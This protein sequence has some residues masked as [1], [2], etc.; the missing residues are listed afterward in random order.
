MSALEQLYRERRPIAELAGRVACVWIQSVSARSDPYVHRT[1][2]NGSVELICTAGS[3][4]RVSGPR[5][6][7]SV[8]VLAPGTTLV[9]IRFLPGAAP[10][11]LGVPASE[12]VDQTME[13][14]ALWGAGAVAL[15]ERIADA[16]SAWAAAAAFEAE[17]AARLADAA[18]PDPIVREAVR[19]LLPWGAGDVTSLP[20]ALFVSERSL[21]RRSREAIGLAPKAVQRILRFQGFLALAHAQRPS[22]PGLALLAAEA[23]YAD[24]SHLTRESLRLS[25]L[26]PRGL[27]S[28]TARHCGPT[29]DHLPS[30]TPLLRRRMLAGSFKR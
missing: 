4:P 29:H 14:A 1:V 22:S 3:L 12:L 21:R 25:G 16:P 30:F 10:A 6:R 2:P 27:L 28:E 20:S 19:R 9:G 24:Q 11:V 7:A 13:L 18:E 15:A 8:D 26:T 17:I 5:T 23:G